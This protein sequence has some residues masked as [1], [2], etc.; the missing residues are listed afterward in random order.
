[1]IEL[2]SQF[3]SGRFQS[4][5]IQK[6][7]ALYFF[8][9]MI[10]FISLDNSSAYFLGDL[11][12]RYAQHTITGLRIVS[13]LMAMHSVCLDLKISSAIRVSLTIIITPPQLSA[14]SFL[15]EV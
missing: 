1:M 3:M 5:P 12:G 9:F 7:L 10:K 6:G 4:P 2:V 15:N 11:G 13:I 14:R 8:M